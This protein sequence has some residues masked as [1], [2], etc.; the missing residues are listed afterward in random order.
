MLFDVHEDL[1]KRLMRESRIGKR[2]LE[3]RSVKLGPNTVTFVSAKS[4]EGLEF[5]E[6]L[7]EKLPM[8]DVADYMDAEE[9]SDTEGDDE[10]E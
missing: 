1:I 10:E 4:E 6:E 5:T 7:S 2:D 9:D 8:I 3:V